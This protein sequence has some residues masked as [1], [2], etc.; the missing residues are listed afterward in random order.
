MTFA[1]PAPSLT[2]RVRPG[3]PL[4]AVLRNPTLRSAA[5]R[6]GRALMARW[7]RVQGCTVVVHEN[8]QTIFSLREREQV[9]WFSVHWAVL[10]LEQDLIRAVA[11]RDALAWERVQ[12]RFGAWAEAAPHAPRAAR[13]ERLEPRGRTHDLSALLAQVN[14]EHFEG[15]LEV[16][17][18]WS[19]W[20]PRSRYGRIRLG[21][22]GGQP[23]RIRVHPALDHPEVPAR[24][25][26]FLLFHELLH[27]AIPP[28]Q[29]TGSRRRVHTPAFRKA[30][31]AHPDYAWAT[32]WETDN[33]G[34]L[35]K[36]A[37][38]RVAVSP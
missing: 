34:A 17:V 4:Q 24:F 18:G 29:G 20:P 14:A 31:R 16:A 23:P 2:V 32:A 33:V 30:E 11:A 36:R 10:D 1:R 9:L 5:A 37:S 6:V 25:L 12:E 35:V 19:R 28:E 8:R 7:P 26:R 27:V 15:R 21:S 22:C 13:V 38:Q 3:P